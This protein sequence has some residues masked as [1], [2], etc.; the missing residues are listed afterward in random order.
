MNNFLT[1]TFLEYP[2]NS[3]ISAIL[4]FRGCDRN[5]KGCQNKDLQKYEPLPDDIIDI[6][7]DYCKRLKTKK[8]VLCGGDPLYI[9]NLPVTRKILNTFCNILDICIYTG[10]TIEEVKKLNISGFK[11]IKC[12]RFDE[13]K[14]INSL[15]TDDFMQFATSNQELYDENL[16]LLSNNGVFKYDRRTVKKTSKN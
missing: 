7:V 4:Y 9:K 2:D 3:S 5:C 13:S 6:I 14:F 10:A 12:G 15:K 11:F 16:N 8:L 1:E